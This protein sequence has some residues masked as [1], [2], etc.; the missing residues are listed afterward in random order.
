[1]LDEMTN[2]SCVQVMYI[3]PST[4]LPTMYS[5][6]QQLWGNVVTGADLCIGKSDDPMASNA[7]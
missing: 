2:Y 3:F 1:M 4:V 7:E 5:L 6:F